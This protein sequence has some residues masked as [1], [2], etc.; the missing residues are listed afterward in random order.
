[1][2]QSRAFIS[3]GL[4][5]LTAAMPFAPAMAEPP[6]QLAS[7]IVE[8]VPIV[9]SQGS[10]LNLT[11]DQKA[12]LDAWMA[13]APTKRK[14]VEKEQV[15]LRASLRKAILSLNADDERKALI[16]Q[17]TTNEARLLSMRAKC[18]DFLRDL[19]TAEQFDKVVAAYKAK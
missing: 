5:A 6:I 8:L 14:A 7:P 13:E 3:A 16:E 1:M 11:A 12:K 10:E 9:K 15:E 17:I 4:F 2:K 18:T 19:L